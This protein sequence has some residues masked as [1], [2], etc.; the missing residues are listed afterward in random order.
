M[1]QIGEKRNAMFWRNQLPLS[2]STVLPIRTGWLTGETPRDSNPNHVQ[3]LRRKRHQA[4]QGLPI[5]AGD[6]TEDPGLNPV[7]RPSTLAVTPADIQQLLRRANSLSAVAPSSP[8][9]DLQRRLEEL[10]P[11][12]ELIQA[13]QNMLRNQNVPDADLP[14][15]EEGS[16]R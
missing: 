4:R 14:Q 2:F 13:L 1:V 10:G 7:P 6:R 11:V 8:V 5:A 12:P 3:T 9:A 15:Y 16:R